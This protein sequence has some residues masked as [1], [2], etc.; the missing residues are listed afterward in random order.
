M[1]N[2][3]NLMQSSFFELFT[4]IIKSFSWWHRM[5]ESGT[6]CRRHGQWSIRYPRY[7]VHM[8]RSIGN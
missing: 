6:K 4:K 3:Q 2:V 1:Q 5:V 8:W 7:T